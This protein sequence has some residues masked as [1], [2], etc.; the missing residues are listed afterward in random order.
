MTEPDSNLIPYGYCH[1]GCGEQT[2]APTSSCSSRGYVK[3]IPHKFKVGHAHRG[4][5]G[6]YKWNLFTNT[7]R[8]DPQTECWIWLQGRDRTGY[9]LLPQTH[10]TKQLGTH[11]AA[12]A[13]YEHFKGEIPNGYHLDHLCRNVVCVNPGH[14]EPV[15]PAVNVQRGDSAKLNPHKVREIRRLYILGE[16]IR[17]IAK[18]FGVHYEHI[19]LVVKRKVWKNV[20]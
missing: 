7:H 3:G 9:A 10:E 5:P 8:I 15:T 2:N 12:R 17:A 20:R 4:R 14:L 16:D 1:C 11:R 19:R 18:Q 6:P 13:Y